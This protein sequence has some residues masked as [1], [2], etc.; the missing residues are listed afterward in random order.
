LLDILVRKAVKLIEISGDPAESVQE[1]MRTSPKASVISE[2]IGN[3][4][5]DTSE[6][7]GETTGT[8]WH[9]FSSLI[10]NTLPRF[11]SEKSIKIPVNSAKAHV[12]LGP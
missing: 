9:I 12:F 4:P 8:E 3:V 2:T 7:S 6:P 5:H 1:G 11:A 10:R